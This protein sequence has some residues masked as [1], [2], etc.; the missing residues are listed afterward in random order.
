MQAGRSY[1]VESRRATDAAWSRWYNVA[2]QAA[3]VVT[4]D[5]PA[6]APGEARFFRVVTPAR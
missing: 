4:F 1:V 2:P 5:E 3:G 6:G